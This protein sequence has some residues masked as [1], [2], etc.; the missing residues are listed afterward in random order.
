MAAP[1]APLS[2][3]SLQ[4]AQLRSLERQLEEENTLLTAN[5]NQLKMAQQKFADAAAVVATLTPDK[6]GAAAAPAPHAPP[7]PCPLSL[8]QPPP[9]P[10]LLLFSARQARRFWCP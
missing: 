8:T 1:G 3:A 4:T 7:Y 2:P 6:K 5:F 9:S 10:P